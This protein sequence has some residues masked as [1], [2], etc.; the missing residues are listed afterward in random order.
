MPDLVE[1]EVRVGR[2]KL[3]EILHQLERKQDECDRLHADNAALADQIASQKLRL[4]TIDADLTP[5]VDEMTWEQRKTL[6]LRQLER[7]DAYDDRQQSQLIDVIAE[8]DRV[9][10][11]LERELADLRELLRQRPGSVEAS[12][13]VGATAIAA[14]LDSD[15]IVQQE[16]D[17]LRQLKEEWHAKMCQ[18]EI[19]LSLERA[20]L[21]RRSHELESE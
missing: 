18:G 6:M 15:E 21:A 17:Q 7:E 16:R 8:T 14:M 4:E 10:S 9:V 1:D 13:V 2:D 5:S 11:D 19:E 12:E 20:K 3:T